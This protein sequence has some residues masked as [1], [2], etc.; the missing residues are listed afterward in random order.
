MNLKSSWYLYQYE[1]LVWY[2]YQYG[3]IDGTPGVK[4]KSL[5]LLLLMLMHIGEF[6]TGMLIYYINLF[7]PRMVMVILKGRKSKKCMLVRFFTFDTL[8]RGKR[9]SFKPIR[10][11]A[12]SP[13]KQHLALHGKNV[14]SRL[15]LIHRT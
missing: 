7:I 14:M 9:P 2:W 12:R 4:P 6:G 3:G 11:S 5:M 10:I 15:Q 13:F 8:M 1:S